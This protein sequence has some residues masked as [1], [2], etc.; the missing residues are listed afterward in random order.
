MAATALVLATGCGGAREVRTQPPRPAVAAPDTATAPE[1][2]ALTVTLG[3]EDTDDLVDDVQDDA[4]LA[5]LG[6]FCRKMG[7]EGR[8]GEIGLVV[9]GRRGQFRDTVE[10]GTHRHDPVVGQVE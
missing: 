9:G 8:Q 1:R 3:I 7:R 4:N 6:A 10:D 5:E 2:T